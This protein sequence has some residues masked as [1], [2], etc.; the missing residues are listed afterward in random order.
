MI[1]FCIKPGRPD[2]VVVQWST[3][4]DIELWTDFYGR[5]ST[6]FIDWKRQSMTIVALSAIVQGKKEILQSYIDCFMQV[7]VEVEGAK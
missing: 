3:E 7:V 5:L 6:H 4:R 2:Q 1:F